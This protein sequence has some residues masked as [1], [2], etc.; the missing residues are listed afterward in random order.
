MRKSKGRG[1]QRLTALLLAVIL[2]LALTPAALADTGDNTPKITQ[3]P[4]QLV[5]QLGA[6]WAGVEF[7]LRTDAGVFPAPVVV[8]EAG[9]LRMDLGGSTTYTLSCIES[10]IPIPDPITDE[11]PGNESLPPADNTPPQQPPQSSAPEPAP[12][13]A[14]SQQS[15]PLVPLIIFLMGLAA[16]GG[17]MAAFWVLKRRQQEDYDEWD[18]EEGE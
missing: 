16:V 9:V 5:L 6:R 11:A 18:D 8:D 10:A 15:V 17:G 4:D 12:A 1:P 3:Q 14:A 2:S 7:E 13:P